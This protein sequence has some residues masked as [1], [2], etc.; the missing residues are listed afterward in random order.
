[1]DIGIRNSLNL[2]HCHY[3]RKTTH[4]S[5]ESKTLIII[6]ECVISNLSFTQANKCQ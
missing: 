6:K 2:K 5:D 3:I 4:L 1:M